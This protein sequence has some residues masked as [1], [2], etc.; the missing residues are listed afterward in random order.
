MIDS[1]YPD[2]TSHPAVQRAPYT[3]VA[4]EIESP[5]VTIITVLTS[6]KR[7]WADTALT[8]ARQSFLAFEWHVVDTTD[9]EAEIAAAQSV[10]AQY[11]YIHYH[12]SPG[13]TIAAARNWAA[14]QAQGDFLLFLEAGD[15]L[16]GTAIEKWY[17]FLLVHRNYGAVSSGAVFFGGFQ[18]LDHIVPPRIFAFPR[19]GDAY[20][21]FVIRRE[22]YE[23]IGGYSETVSKHD[24][25]VDFWFRFAGT[26]LL[27][28]ALPEYL[29][30]CPTQEEKDPN[31]VL[32]PVHK[33][34]YRAPWEWSGIFASNRFGWMHELFEFKPNNVA[35][36][37]RA[38][39]LVASK[40]RILLAIPFLSLGGSEKAALDIIEQLVHHGWDVT[41]LSTSDKKNDWYCEF[42]RYTPDIFILPHFVDPD[43]I[44][45]HW[46]AFVDYLMQSRGFDAVLIAN[47]TFVMHLLPYLKARYP[48][49]AFAM[50]RHADIWPRM[51]QEYHPLLD[52]VFVS[53][54]G[55][56]RKMIENGFNV[57]N[58]EVY[59]TNVDTKTW[60]PDPVARQ[61]VRAW[62][63]IPQDVPVI[64]FS[65]RLVD[66]KQPQIMAEVVK[67]LR[68]KGHR[69][70]GIVTGQGPR[71]QWLKDF[72]T[73]HNLQDVLHVVGRLTSADMPRFMSA[74]DI[75]FLPSQMEGIAVSIFEAMACGMTVV[76]ADIGGQSELVTPD[77]GVLISREPED[78]ECSRY[79]EVFE[80]LLA[81]PAKLAAM[82]AAATTRINEH[83]RIEQMGQQI[84]TRLLRAVEYA[85]HRQATE[86]P[87]CY[88]RASAAAA[89]EVAFGERIHATL[90]GYIE[91]IREEYERQI[92]AL[93]QAAASTCHHVGGPHLKLWSRVSQKAVRGARRACGGVGR[94]ARRLASRCVTPILARAK[95]RLAE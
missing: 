95:S 25:E 77:C 82:K 4:G 74:G 39:R 17:W 31:V 49:C 8:I 12:Q 65:A 52:V 45:H 28:G 41:V 71:L 66:M 14:R 62:L 9:D 19:E 26:G 64:V 78:T 46:V 57:D 60:H 88:A 32:A 36:T 81:D 40:P 90:E 87:E 30:W 53:Y 61:Q 27:S 24:R 72:V 35:V 11:P 33:A 15:L 50:V 56:R 37:S 42:A 55:I 16:E 22:T 20:R 6:K 38:N 43:V 91:E 47:N 23:Q 84:H 7:D 80:Q 48:K 75:F 5:A 79:L 21:T 70:A 44:P 2:Y 58:V 86:V 68:D 54:N 83:F 76:S 94:R 63:N 29:K 51:A 69:I 73:E 93:K 34:E 92:T 89:A 59:T 1:H 85:R 10:A 67:Q 13:T 18:K 3:Y